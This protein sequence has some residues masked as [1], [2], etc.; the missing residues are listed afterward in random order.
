MA[1]LSVEKEGIVLDPLEVELDYFCLDRIKVAGMELR[2]SY[3]KPN[4]AS[5]VP[6]L[7]E[8][9][10]LYANDKLVFSNLTLC[11]TKLTWKEM[12]LS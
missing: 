5:D 9:Y 11:R 4:M 7:E 3:R 8:G 12:D 1:G 6:D 2:I 10:R